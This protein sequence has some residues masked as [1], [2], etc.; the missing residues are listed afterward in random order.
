MKDALLRDN[1]ANE[2][3]DQRYDRQTAEGEI[4]DMGHDRRAA[5][6]RRAD[7][8]FAKRH[9]NLA[10]KGDAIAQYLLGLR[11][12]DGEGTAADPLLAYRWMNAAAEAGVEQAKA[13][14]SE[15]IAGLSSE[16]RRELGLPA[17]VEAPAN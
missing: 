1:A 11:Y 8:H 2:K 14:R 15:I 7:D 9:D 5:Q 13:A 16:Q 4:L 17:P 12:Q 3:I 10:E 6:T